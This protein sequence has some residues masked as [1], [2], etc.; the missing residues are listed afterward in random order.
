M[1]AKPAARRNNGRISSDSEDSE[2]ERTVTCRICYKEY[3]GTVGDRDVLAQHMWRDHRRQAEVLGY[4]AEDNQRTY[5]KETLAEAVAFGFPHQKGQTPTPTPPTSAGEKSDDDVDEPEPIPSSRSESSESEA[6]D[7]GSESSTLTW[8]HSSGEEATENGEYMEPD[9]GQ[10]RLLPTGR[11]SKGMASIKLQVSSRIHVRLNPGA[12]TSTSEDPVL[13]QIRYD[14]RRYKY[15]ERADGSARTRPRYKERPEEIRPPPVITAEEMI[16]LTQPDIPPRTKKGREWMK[17]EKDWCN[18]QPKPEDH[19]GGD[20][21]AQ[22]SIE[23]GTR[24][25]YLFIGEPT[26]KIR[27]KEIFWEDKGFIWVATRDRYTGKLLQV[28]IEGCTDTNTQ[29][30]YWETIALGA[31]AREHF[32]RELL[33]GD[34]GGPGVIRLMIPKEVEEPEFA[35]NGT[36]TETTT[37]SETEECPHK[38]ALRKKAIR[39]IRKR[40]KRRQG[41]QVKH[42]LRTF[43]IP[44]QTSPHLSEKQPLHKSRVWKHDIPSGNCY[45]NSMTRKGYPTAFP[46][47]KDWLLFGCSPDPGSNNNAYKRSPYHK[48]KWQT[49]EDDRRRVWVAGYTN[50][51][52][53]RDGKNRLARRTLQVLTISHFND[54][55]HTPGEQGLDHQSVDRTRPY[56]RE[57]KGPLTGRR[58]YKRRREEDGVDETVREEYFMA[59]KEPKQTRQQRLEDLQTVANNLTDP[60]GEGPILASSEVYRK[61]DYQYILDGF[62]YQTWSEMKRRYY[63]YCYK[64]RITAEQDFDGEP[65]AQIRSWPEMV[66]FTSG[67]RAG[68]LTIELQAATKIPGYRPERARQWSWYSFPMEC[69]RAKMFTERMEAATI[70]ALKKTVK[71]GPGDHHKPEEEVPSTRWWVNQPHRYVRPTP[72]RKEHLPDNWTE[73][74]P[75][76]YFS[77]TTFSDGFDGWVNPDDPPTYWSNPSDG[78][79]AEERLHEP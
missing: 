1:A 70:A 25:A 47:L 35:P 72:P 55:R 54:G 75:P 33:V 18:G 76:E 29:E 68:Y 24:G 36:T 71:T 64:W 21:P 50:P 48:Y 46:K 43:T 61:T 26:K 2:P 3:M 37:G 62:G 6:S 59:P 69:R 19:E 30:G 51:K 73:W 40:R 20:V 77:G 66:S 8:D 27:P 10:R 45:R 53:P 38:T 17:Q 60:Y 14:K 15:P 4:T 79:Y 13:R 56:E 32:P 5:T 67:F 16:K 28:W 39:G 74:T 9:T 22:I 42:W 23:T 41:R 7:P 57:K 34:T 12:G 49:Y 65:M 11:W 63:G 31:Y 58:R 52:T 44:D 78:E